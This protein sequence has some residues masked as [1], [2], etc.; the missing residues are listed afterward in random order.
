MKVL[1]VGPPHP[2]TRAEPLVSQLVSS[3]LHVNSVQRI[4]IFSLSLSLV[5]LLCFVLVFFV[6]VFLNPPRAFCV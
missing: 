2:W 3:F 4:V 5:V 6:F 1:R